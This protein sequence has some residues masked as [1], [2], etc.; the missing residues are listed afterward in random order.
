[1]LDQ[2]LYGM[3]GL[4]NKC[5]ARNAMLYRSAC[6]GMLG[7]VR[8]SGPMRLFGRSAGVRC[9]RKDGKCEEGCDL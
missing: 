5:S 6:D 7:F 9:S 4:S 3:Y 2:L 8:G 1:M